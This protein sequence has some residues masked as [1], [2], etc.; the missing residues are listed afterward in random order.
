MREKGQ[1]GI[2]TPFFDKNAR[3]GKNNASCVF[4]FLF[5]V[6]A[7]VI[8]FIYKNRLKDGVVSEFIYKILTLDELALNPLSSS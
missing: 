7:N 1:G 6:L 4:G 3:T 5:L 2:S 8:R